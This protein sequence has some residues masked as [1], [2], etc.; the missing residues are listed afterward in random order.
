[1]PHNPLT[2][3]G[4]PFLGKTGNQRAD[5]GFQHLRKHAERTFPRQSCQR[6]DNRSGLVKRMVVSDFKG[7]LLLV[8]FWLAL[9]PATLRRPS[10]HSST[11]SPASLIKRPISRLR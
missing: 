5:F 9:T 11:Q 3:V 10:N 6:I 7:V 8:G 4:Q 1:M 2:A